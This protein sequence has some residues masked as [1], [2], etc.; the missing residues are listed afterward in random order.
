MELT[1]YPNYLIYRDGRVFS[2][3]SGIF[4]KGGM[5]SSK[6]QNISLCHNGKSKTYTRHRLVAQYYIPNPMNLPVV[7]HIDRNKENNNVDNL[8]WTTILFN[9]H[10]VGKYSSNTSGHKNLY[11]RTNRKSW[12]YQY[13]IRQKIIYRRCFKNKIDC[14][15][16]KFICLLRIK[17]TDLC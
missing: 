16:Y 7:D 1:N 12:T 4:I 2:K 17:T 6:Y 8:R 13:R 15:C 9:S 14:L 10:N 5:C 3:K 11:F